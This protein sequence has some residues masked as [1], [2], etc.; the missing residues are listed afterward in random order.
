MLKRIHIFL[1]AFAACVGTSLA[2]A[3]APPNYEFTSQ[4]EDA[5]FHAKESGL[6]APWLFGVEVRHR[7]F[8]VSLFAG[9]GQLS[10]GSIPFQQLDPSVLH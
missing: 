5:C 9:P 2:V 6:P 1:V 7:T 3:Y 8:V 4:M 10:L